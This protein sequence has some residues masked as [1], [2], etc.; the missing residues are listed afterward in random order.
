MSTPLRSPKETAAILGVSTKTV[1]GYVRDGEL[2][3]INVGRG[4]KKQRR[5]FTDEDID[6]F[7]QGRG[8]RDVPCQSTSTK[9]ARSIT[10]TSGSRVLAFTALRDARANEKL[11][12]SNATNGTGPGNR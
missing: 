2:R 10:S 11:K 12:R 1:D 8:K 5:M 3:Y 9:T 7:I 6:D 4:T